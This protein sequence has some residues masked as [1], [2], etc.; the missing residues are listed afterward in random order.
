MIYLLSENMQSKTFL[1]IENFQIEHTLSS[2]YI[3][4]FHKKQNQL[5]H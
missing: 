1:M 3:T 4:E 2:T 5:M